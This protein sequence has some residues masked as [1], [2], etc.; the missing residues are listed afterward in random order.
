M[1]ATP[2]MRT[3]VLVTLALA[4]V[5]T[6]SQ[7]QS[8]KAGETLMGPRTQRIYMSEDGD[9]L[10]I[11]APK[12]SRE[13]VLIDGVEG[14]L[15]DE[16]P[17]NFGWTSYRGS[18]GPMVFS[19]TGG[20]SAYVARRAGDFIAVVDGKEAVTLSTPATAQG[21][22]Y[23][24]P[25]GWNFWFNHDGSRL[26]YAAIGG[27]ASWVMVVDGVKSPPYHGFDF[28]QTALNGK[29]LVYVAQVTFDMSWHVVVDGKV[30]PGYAKISSLQLTPDGAH[31]AFIATKTGAAGAAGGLVVVDGVEG[32]SYPGGVSELEQAPDGR[33][34]YMVVKPQTSPG[35]N[36][37]HLIVGGLDIPNTTTFGVTIRAGY[38]SPQYDV[39]WSPDGKRFA[40]V[41][42]NRP[43]PGVT[44]LV[45]GKP[46]GQ[47][48]Q[49]ANELVWSPDGSRLAYQGG[50]PTGT[51]PVIDGQEL[52]G[53]HWIKEFQWSPDGK[54]YAFYGANA[55]G[56]WMVVDGKEQ[57]KAFGFSDGA[58][59]FSPVGN[60]IAYGAQ[61]TVANYQPIVDGVAIPHNL[62]N[63]AAKNQTNP[64]TFLPVF[65]YSP[66]GNHLA[67]VG[68]KNDGTSKIGVWVDGVSYQGP[69]QSYF[70][71]AW[72]P[73]SKHLAVV[74]SNG[75]GKGWSIMVDGKLSQGYEDLIELNDASSRFV[76]AHTFRFYA[77]KGT[78]IYR[79][80]LDI[81]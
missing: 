6:P 77:V 80:T 32:P 69:L 63:F 41:Q 81:P 42:Q 40:A 13:I 20:R 38:R 62:G 64:P 12:G 17:L 9:H 22:S 53:Y 18:L 70:N 8:A 15:F 10:A 39:A 60:H 44:V 2:W 34:A 50:S 55:T 54:R 21:V 79:E 3:A 19:P 51:F 33:V 31:Y 48:Y 66:D 5:V 57:P 28:T 61:S 52:S 11:V 24:D 16:I 71:P 78:D 45:N 68:A 36:P 43:N 75:S 29:R 7:G 59:R 47:T 27:P 74:T 35:G 26:A 1:S 23:S 56:I 14:P 25:A 65:F 73:D 4:G 72:S 67:Y 46:M 37:P 30:G 58:L 76:D 49:T